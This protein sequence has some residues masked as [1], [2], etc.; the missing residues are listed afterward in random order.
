MSISWASANSGV[1]PMAQESKMRS[2]TRS[3]KCYVIAV[4]CDPKIPSD[5]GLKEAQPTERFP[6]LLIVACNKWSQIL[7][8]V[9]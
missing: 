9:L 6:P 7:H 1:Y 8:C 4:K 3:L 5:L 2:Y